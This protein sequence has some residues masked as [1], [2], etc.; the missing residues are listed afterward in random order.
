MQTITEEF[1]TLV[2]PADDAKPAPTTKK[3][4]KR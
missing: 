2:T 1:T 4:A 3:K